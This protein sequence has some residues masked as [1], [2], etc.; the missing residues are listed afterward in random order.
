[1][2]IDVKSG[3]TISYE[4]FQH[5]ASTLKEGEVLYAEP[6]E[7]G[8]RIWGDKE[9]F[10]LFESTQR[11]EQKKLACDTLL[12]CNFPGDKKPSFESQNVV[13]SK[14]MKT[15]AFPSKVSVT[16]FSPSTDVMIA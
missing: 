11:V 7:G 9:G 13:S 4:Q 2:S 3:K 1:M 15:Q 12:K 8:V 10:S 14:S 6:T 16:S 5:L